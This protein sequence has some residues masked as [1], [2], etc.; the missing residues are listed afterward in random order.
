M[1]AKWTN[2]RRSFMG[3]LEQI[4][5]QHACLLHVYTELYDFQ[6]LHCTLGLDKIA[7]H[8]RAW[9]CARR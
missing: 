1:A 8:H 7:G 2:E 9:V 6:M 3:V 4:Y 5:Q